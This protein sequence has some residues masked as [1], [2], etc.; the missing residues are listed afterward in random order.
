M[1]LRYGTT[2][3]DL[4]SRLNMLPV[5]L[6]PPEL[7]RPLVSYGD[8]L[9]AHCRSPDT[10]PDPGGKFQPALISLRMS[11]VRRELRLVARM[12]REV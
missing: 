2:P 9:T 11:S 5:L 12:L 3:A 4:R 6:M 7:C 1:G 10:R 8:N